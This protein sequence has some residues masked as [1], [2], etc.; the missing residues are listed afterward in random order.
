[1][2]PSWLERA[3]RA[4]LSNYFPAS[5]TLVRGEGCRVFDDS[6]KSYLDLVSG[7][8]VNNLGHCHPAV[9]AAIREQAGTL[10][11]VSNLYQHPL[12]VRLAERLAEEFREGARFSATAEPRRTR[13]RSSWFENIQST[14]TERHATSSLQLTTPSTAGPSPP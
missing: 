11:H 5:L 13:Q 3:N 4:L 1:M 12:H 2:E 8:S 9:V 6:G 14:V 10:M 7:I